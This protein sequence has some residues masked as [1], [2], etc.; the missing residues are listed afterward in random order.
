MTKLSSMIK[1]EAPSPGRIN[2]RDRTHECVDGPDDAF[3]RACHQPALTNG[4]VFLAYRG[5]DAAQARVI[6]LRFHLPQNRIHRVSALCIQKRK[7]PPV[8]PDQTWW[9][10]VSGPTYVPLP[11][12][13]T[14]WHAVRTL[15]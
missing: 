4:R 14:A 8:D 11:D 3:R 9:R 15:R 7:A 2:R 10:G 6:R 1:P 12:M 5:F 13:L